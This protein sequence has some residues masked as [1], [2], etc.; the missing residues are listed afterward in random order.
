MSHTRGRAEADRSCL[1]MPPH[2]FPLPSAPVI[3]EPEACAEKLARYR[4]TPLA[5]DVYDWCIIPARGNSMRE[6]RF[7]DYR[8]STDW[9]WAGLKS[10]FKNRAA[11]FALLAVVLVFLVA[12]L[13]YRFKVLPTLTATR[14]DLSI[15]GGPEGTTIKIDDE[16]GVVQIGGAQRGFATFI[17]SDDRVYVPT[18]N[19]VDGAR[20]GAWLS[21]PTTAVLDDPELFTYS[22]IIEA[23]DRGPKECALPSVAADSIIKLLIVQHFSKTEDV[24][25]YNICGS[26]ISGGAFADGRGVR[27]DESRIRPDGIDVPSAE[28]VVTIE[29]LGS[30]GAAV[31]QKVK[32]MFSATG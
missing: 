11:L 30:D 10:A 14:L 16:R 25:R 23:L 9:S 18:D 13:Y 3:T 19:V 12:P 26:G 1:P 2:D 4:R 15:I 17:V 7:E 8:E 21:I 20:K 6:A 5:R 24:T 22:H 32:S 31:L 29:S 27:V 28:A